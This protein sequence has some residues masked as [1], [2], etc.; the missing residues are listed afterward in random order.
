MIYHLAKDALLKRA[1]TI[2]GNLGLAKPLPVTPLTPGKEAVELTRQ[3][4]DIIIK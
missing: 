3:A 4:S 1:H 2:P